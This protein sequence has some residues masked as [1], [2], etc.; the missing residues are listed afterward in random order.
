MKLIGDELMSKVLNRKWMLHVP[1]AE[2]HRIKLSPLGGRHRDGPFCN[3]SLLNRGKLCFGDDLVE[4]ES[5]DPFFYVVRDDLLHP[6][7]N[8]NKARKLDALLPLLVDHSVTDVVSLQ[9]SSERRLHLCWLYAIGLCS[10]CC[11]LCD[12]ATRRFIIG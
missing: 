10:Y 1:D 11:K 4:K 8:G 7:V 3:F 9:S 6:L 5:K 12:H 2:I